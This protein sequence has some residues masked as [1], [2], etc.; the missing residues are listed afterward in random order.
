MTR[1]KV[2]FLKNSMLAANFLA[3]FIAIFIVLRGFLRIAEKW[4]DQMLTNP[5]I[6][7]T[8]MIFTPATFIFVWVMTLYYERPIRTYLNDRFRNRK[9]SDDLENKARQRLL[10]EPFILIALDLSMWVLS[11][12]VWAT[13]C[14]VTGSGSNWIQR[15]LYMS[16]STGFITVTLAFFLLEHVLER[17]LVPFFFP[18]GGLSAVPKT[19]RIRISTRLVALLFACNLIP[20]LSILQIFHRIV[21]NNQDSSVALNLF[22]SVLLASSF[23]FILAGICLTLLVNRSLTLP[24]GEIIKTLQEVKKGNFKEK[25]QVTRNDEI[26]YTGDVINEMSH[27]LEERE[28]IKDT[29]GKYV[30]KEVGVEIL[31][32]KI[33]FD[34]EKKDVTILFA[35]LRDFTR[36]TE[37]IEPKEMV[38]ILNN[39][40][41]EMTEAVQQHSGTILRYVGDEIYAVFGA[42]FSL[43]HHQSH[44]VEAALEMNRRLVFVNKELK[45]QNYGPLKHGIGI[46]SGSVIAAIIGGRDRLSYDMVGDTVNLASR[47]QNL[48][49][50]FSIDILISGTTK[51]GLNTGHS[52]IKL[53]KTKVKGR[54]EPVE[55]YRFT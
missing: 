29:F 6:V 4:P 54:K 21:G 36:L 32:G 35:D 25:I 41:A 10:N 46:H 51:A 17:R 52:L 23:V 5:I 28:V 8:N 31:S 26:G 37:S 22:S 3:N 50:K 47:I 43:N 34:G 49:K 53:T 19:I 40:F 24:F 9:V 55:I 27:G 2:F 45:K 1:I 20:L 33:P 16:L 44:A 48:T 14:W 42:P 18:E 12:V 11:A 7:W 15:A 13:L 30:D 38:Y 39:Y